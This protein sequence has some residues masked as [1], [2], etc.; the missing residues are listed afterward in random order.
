MFCAKW[1]RSPRGGLECVLPFARDSRHGRMTFCRP[2]LVD[3]HS[4]YGI[5]IRIHLQFL[6]LFL[7]IAYGI[8]TVGKNKLVQSPRC[9]IRCSNVQ[10]GVVL[11]IWSARVEP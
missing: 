7:P 10:R 4:L 11:P 1:C 8:V 6:A 3:Q 2:E 9:Y 5:R